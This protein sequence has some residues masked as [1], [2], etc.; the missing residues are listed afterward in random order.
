[1]KITR[2]FK[3]KIERNTKNRAIK[4]AGK[5]LVAAALLGL[6]LST[7]PYG[8]V[9]AATKTGETPDRQSVGTSGF[10]INDGETMSTWSHT[11]ENK[12]TYNGLI[13]LGDG[14][15]WRPL[16]SSYG[17]KAKLVT[18][19]NNSVIDLAYKYT[20]P[21]W[22]GADSID[23][24]SN[25]SYRG[26]VFT[27]VDIGKNVNI[28][29]NAG[30]LGGA[31]ADA[32]CDSITFTDWEKITLPKD[33]ANIN[34]VVRYQPGFGGIDW[35]ATKNYYETGKFNVVNIYGAGFF[36]YVTNHDANFEADIFADMDAFGAQSPENYELLGNLMLKYNNW[37][38]VA[39]AYLEKYVPQGNLKDRY[40][41]LVKEFYQRIENF[42]PKLTFTKTDASTNKL[43]LD[44]NFKKYS[45]TSWLTK[46]G[47][48]D[49]DH[50]YYYQDLNWEARCT[51][52][53]SQGVFSAANAQLSMRNLWRME[54]GLFWKRGEDLRAANSQGQSEGADGAWAQVWRGKYDFDGAY[55]SSFGQNYN[56][57]QVGYDKQREEKLFGGKLYTGLFLSLLNSDADFHQHTI[58]SGTDEGLYSGSTGDLKSGGIG[59]YTSWLGDTGHYLDLTVRGSKLSNNNKFYDSYNVLYDNDYGTW[60]YGA[61]VR[62][63]YQ[64]EMPGGWYLEPQ[65][66]LTY[67]TMKAYSYTQDNNMRYNQDKLEM[68][69]G[70]LGLTAGRN[71]T[72]GDRKGRVYVKAAVNHDFKDGGSASADAM[73]YDS[74]HQ[75]E[76]VRASMA[77]DTLA[78]HDTW[79][80]FALGTNLQTGRDKNA[81]VELTKTVGGKVNTDWQ[82]NAGMSWRFNGPSSSE[83]A[84]A[85]NAAFDRSMT[86]PEVSPAAKAAAKPQTT[87]AVGTKTAADKATQAAQ[88][89]QANK[90]AQ[91]GQTIQPGQEAAGTDKTVAGDKLTPPSDQADQKTQANQEE[92]AR[93]GQAGQA[94]TGERPAAAAGTAEPETGTIVTGGNEPGSFALA[95]VVVEA[96]RPDWEKNLSPGTVS[97]IHVPEYKGEMKNLPDLLQTVPGVYVQ[98]LSGT[99][100]YAVAR[101]RGSSGGQVNIY[102][103]GV[104]A[105]SAS[106]A[107]VDL[108]TIPVENVERVEVYRGYVPARFAGSPL[109]GAI[110][111][112]T[113]KPQESKGSIST[114]MRSF[115]G[116]T[117]NLELT[118]PLGEGSLLFALNRDQSQGDFR[119]DKYH[120]GGNVYNVTESRWRMNNDYHNTDALLKWQ[121]DHWFAKLT[122]KN[123][124]T[125]LPESACDDWV[126]VPFD[127][128]PNKA[129]NFDDYRKRYLETT[130][131]ELSLGRR[132]TAGNLEW[133]WKLDTS[134]QHKEATNAEFKSGSAAMIFTT[135]D[136][137]FR[138]RRYEGAIDGSWKMGKNHLVEFLFDCSRETMNVDTNNFDVWP[139]NDSFVGVI[140]S[141]KQ[142]FKTDYSTN[143][144]FFQVQDT[145]TLNKSGN[146]FFTPVLR[147]QKMTMNVDLGDPDLGEWEYSY[148]LGLKKV[149]NDHWTFRSTYGTYY[150][151]P[152]FYELFG[153]GVNVLSRWE[154]Y[155]TSYSDFLLNSYVER[156][157]SWDV[158]ANWQGK[159]FQADADV[160]LTYFN[161]DVKNLSTYAINPYGYGYYSNLAAG[162]IQGVELESKL[163]WQRWNLLQ[164]VTWNDSLITKSGMFNMVTKSNVNAGN[165]FPWTPKWETNTRLSYRFPGDKL[166]V[167]G[168]YHYLGKVGQYTGVGGRY[169]YDT[170]GL[171]NVG[172]KYGFNDKV[173]L[174]AGVNDLFNEGPN[175][176]WRQNSGPSKTI[177]NVVYPQQGRT[178]YLTMQYFF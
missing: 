95:P 128:I 169:F 106:D 10:T 108:S 151:F 57:I 66:G 39:A 140:D 74:W 48:I 136:N 56:G 78:G 111:I 107:A 19:G 27:T 110:N 126:D 168:E 20:S 60:T 76:I 51:D 69:T 64:K 174:T 13:T 137:E 31:N 47:S 86:A 24:S 160:T 9:Y 119:Y 142:Y 88:P 93:T 43:L 91:D 164:S 46:D 1:M 8:A 29:L 32:K 112:V 85:Q 35:N 11:T 42:E 175:Q 135:A 65:V 101:V 63:G 44:G 118:A 36:Q 123:N 163:N 130:K 162:K 21:N 62:Y 45:I 89:A 37:N 149:Q 109:G 166:T 102:I 131:T 12:G 139:R 134:Y 153:D 83:R 38:A 165:P 113:K 92:Q 145:M 22:A 33:G 2:K 152:N 15:V 124:K 104:L 100:H 147:G 50:Y 146:L 125:K 79:Y 41:A 72:N 154:M 178:Y 14:A 7:L 133:G 81:F 59:L 161:R 18:L 67:G 71:F 114:G 82:V 96:A 173:K 6:A 26:I 52:L 138:N 158:S 80:E 117:G 3:R 129:G 54:N 115:G 98:R 97:V 30:G 28:T 122:Y 87:T 77:V 157:T 40:T 73:S 23:W 99:G 155:R 94:D 171:T 156:G 70:R 5:K 34:L 143:N 68:L 17:V 144:Y 103:D 141:Y 176:L 127:E 170:L 172:L 120:P 84:A 148:G 53:V 121:D 55:G 167:F 16:D 58:K 90:T 150:K 75:K 49:V 177:G 105:N 116:Y 4:Q 61:G 132:Q 25:Q 159:A